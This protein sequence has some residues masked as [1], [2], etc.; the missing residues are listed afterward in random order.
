MS[1]VLYWTDDEVA[2]LR[3]RYAGELS[4]DIAR[5]LGRPVRAVHE[6]ARKLGLRKDLAF[7]A[8]CTRRAVAEPTH[9][10]QRTRFG[11][12]APPW[13]KGVKG[14]TGLHPATA[15][16]HFKPGQIM[17]R[18]AQ[19]VLPLGTLRVTRDG[20]LER[21]VGTQSGP[22]HLRWRPVH[23]LVWESVHGPV[24]AGHVVAFKPGRKTT[25]AQ[26][27]TPDALELLTLA[28]NMARNS[29]HRKYP[30]ELVRLV[31]LRA[32]L[33]RQINQKAKEAAAHE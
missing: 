2:L 8:E 9:G 14:S 28:Q 23:R 12:D 30:P 21:K 11:V 31:N 7:V 24:P 22:S 3:A 6:K 27:I 4:R 10:S 1:R 13:N 20:T 16:N 17:G 15:A 29:V 26:D 33:T 19:L 25:A 5:A 32:A 18:A